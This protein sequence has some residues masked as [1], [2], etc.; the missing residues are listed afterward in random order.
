MIR[1]EQLVFDVSAARECT[2]LPIGA[3][4][5]KLNND[6]APHRACTPIK[7]PTKVGFFI[8]APEYSSGVP[9]RN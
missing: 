8:G 5:A 7:N 4:R 3:G 2:I 6:N 1:H 9:F